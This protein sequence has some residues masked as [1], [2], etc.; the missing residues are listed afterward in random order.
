MIQLLLPLALFLSESCWDTVTIAEVPQEALDCAL[1]ASAESSQGMLDYAVLLEMS[2]RF[3]EAL[4]EY[5]AII[6]SAPDQSTVSWIQDRM[7]GCAPLDTTIVI[8]TTI[9]NG[10]SNPVFD[11]TLLHPIPVSHSPYQE[12]ELMGGDYNLKSNHL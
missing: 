2:G 12:I 10:G 11:I 3:Q 1:L 6:E 9:S 8:E 7:A 5:S 4:T